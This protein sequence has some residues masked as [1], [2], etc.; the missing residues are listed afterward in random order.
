MGS[1]SF[2]Y[3]IYSYDFYITEVDNYITSI[4]LNKID[5]YKYQ[6]TPLIK[7]AQKEL[8][9]YFAGKRTTFNLPLK[10]TGTEFQNKV[11][12]KLQEIPYGE[13]ISYSALA[14]LINHPKSARAVGNALNK[15]KLLIVVPCHRVVAKHGLGGFGA[16]L[17]LKI[18]LLELENYLK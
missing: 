3:N 16:N 13:V 14:S 9:E 1:F 11:W 5:N 2:K 18:Q 4:S 17:S 7:E 15:N 12:T 8:T 10:L 6:E